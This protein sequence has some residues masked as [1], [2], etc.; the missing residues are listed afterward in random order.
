MYKS[1]MGPQW[2]LIR[3]YMDPMWGPSGPSMAPYQDPTWIKC[4][5]S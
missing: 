5:H 1:F 4:V 3:T 2:I